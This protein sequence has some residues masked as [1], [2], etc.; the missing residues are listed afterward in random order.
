MTR[1]VAFFPGGARPRTVTSVRA[2]RADQ[3]S[4]KTA[5]PAFVAR[6]GAML[7]GGRASS[8]LASSPSAAL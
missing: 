8:G 5:V 3:Q 6:S 2:T 1:P 7:V 4:P